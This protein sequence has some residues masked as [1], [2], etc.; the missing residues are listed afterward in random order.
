MNQFFGHADEIF[1]KH[2]FIGS[3]GTNIAGPDETK[4]GNI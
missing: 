2:E 3:M 1:N 4:T